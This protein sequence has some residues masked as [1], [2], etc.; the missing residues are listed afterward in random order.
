MHCKGLGLT[1]KPFWK[2]GSLLKNII[3]FNH[4][5]LNFNINKNII[6][7]EIAC[8]KMQIFHLHFQAKKL[9]SHLDAES[10]FAGEFLNKAGPCANHLVRAI[11]AV[12]PGG[13]ID[14]LTKHT[15]QLVLLYL[16]LHIYL[17]YLFSSSTIPT[18]P[19]PN[20]VY[21]ISTH[22]S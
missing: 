7:S 2:G 15:F 16:Y 4:C 11:V 1:H 21:N 13:E 22:N 5:F 19:L 9:Y 8:L 14:S 18:L 17:L 20:D 3:F 6:L 12:S 10:I